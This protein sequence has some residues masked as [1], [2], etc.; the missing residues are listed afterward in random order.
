[1]EM[2][3][4]RLL[5]WLLMLVI[6]VGLAF[7]LMPSWKKWPASS[8][9][10]GFI[11]APGFR[12]AKACP[13]SD[14]SINPEPWDLYTSHWSDLFYVV[15]LLSSYMDPVEYYRPYSSLTGLVA[16]KL[17]FNCTGYTLYEL[18]P[19]PMSERD[20]EGLTKL[21]ITLCM[22]HYYLIPPIE[23]R[24]AS[25]KTFE[26]TV[27]AIHNPCTNASEEAVVPLNILTYAPTARLNIF[28]RA[29]SVYNL[30]IWGHAN[31][32]VD[33]S[34]ESQVVDEK[35]S[36]DPGLNKTVCNVT[37]YSKHIIN[38]NYTLVIV[39]DNETILE[40]YKGTIDQSHDHY[41]S[42]YKH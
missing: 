42:I 19:L 24:L 23:L 18:H 14:T 27:V 29:E 10:S 4:L 41:E 36:Y 38:V 20:N 16:V 30:T 40:D 26:E 1:M 2:G 28:T 25:N 21:N 5:A 39:V 31:D 15:E 32:S 6:V 17:V 33:Y 22:P 13:V 8:P 7:S 3:L 34:L 37:I 11:T 9:W 12:K 35:C